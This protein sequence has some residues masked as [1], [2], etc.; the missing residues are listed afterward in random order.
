MNKAVEIADKLRQYIPNGDGHNSEFAND[1]CEA[2]ELLQS[3]GKRLDDLERVCEGLSQDTI[4]GGFTL[5]MLQSYAKGLERRLDAI[6]FQ[7]GIDV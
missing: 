6:R 1:L 7:A 4:D 5:K 2:V 3:M